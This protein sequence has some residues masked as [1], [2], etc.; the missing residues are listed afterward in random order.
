[1]WLGAFVFL[2][3]QAIASPG[4]ADILSD[5]ETLMADQER[6]NELVPFEQKLCTDKGT[7]AADTEACIAEAMWEIFRKIPNKIVAIDLLAEHYDRRAKIA[8]NMNTHVITVE[9]ARAQAEESRQI[10]LKQK[11]RRLQLAKDTVAALQQQQE[12]QQ[13][14]ADQAAAEAAEQEKKRRFN[15]ALGE[16]GRQ[17]LQPKVYAQP[18]ANS[19][20]PTGCRRVGQH[21]EGFNKICYYDCMGGPFALNL[22]STDICP[23]QP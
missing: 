5:V 17:M 4:S 23:I 11:D 18:E 3:A 14:A 19:E 13:R 12:D 1:M 2:L 21:R 9:Q 22:S 6:A 8:W 7:I 10:Y 16:L 20:T 15:N